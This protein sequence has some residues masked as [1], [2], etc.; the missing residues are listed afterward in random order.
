MECIYSQKDTFLSGGVLSAPVRH[1]ERVR[2]VYYI[3]S[4]SEHMWMLNSAQFMISFLRFFL[5]SFSASIL[6]LASLATIIMILSYAR[7]VRCC[8][9]RLS[10][11]T[12]FI[13]CVRWHDFHR[14]NS[15]IHKSRSS[16][17]FLLHCHHI[18]KC[19][20]ASK[21]YCWIF[22]FWKKPSYVKRFY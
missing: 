7:F 9:H 5:S 15:L 17:F 3:V 21:L 20:F 10:E 19:M 8:L 2:F 1:S 12:I 18:E 4:N 22:C 11:E 6:D 14:S 16:I 13:F